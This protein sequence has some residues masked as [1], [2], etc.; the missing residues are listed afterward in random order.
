MITHRILTNNFSR[1][2]SSISLASSGFCLNNSFTVSR[3][4]PR[5]SPLYENQEPDFSTIS[6]LVARSKTS[7]S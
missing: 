4:C 7:P 6:K 2:F 1:T 3:P 5:R